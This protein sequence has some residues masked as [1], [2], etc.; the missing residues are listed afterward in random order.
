MGNCLQPKQRSFFVVKKD[1]YIMYCS[2][3]QKKVEEYVENQ[4]WICRANK[5]PTTPKY[6]IYEYIAD[7]D[8]KYG[9]I[10]LKKTYEK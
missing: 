9:F 8:D 10:F 6:E 5:I 2:Q 3:F 4:L 1:G 7:G